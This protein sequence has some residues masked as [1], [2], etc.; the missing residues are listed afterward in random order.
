MTLLSREY[1]EGQAEDSPSIEVLGKQLSSIGFEA[2]RRAATESTVGLYPAVYGEI[3]DQQAAAE[4]LIRS[5]IEEGNVVTLELESR[6]R[7]VTGISEVNFNRV[8]GILTQNKVISYVG[9]GYAKSKTHKDLIAGLNL[10][11]EQ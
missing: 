8:I 9:S 10:V 1:P 11:S 7:T 2:V 4:S 5:I 3:L 6:I